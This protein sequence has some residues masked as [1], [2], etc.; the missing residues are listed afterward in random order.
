MKL[1]QMGVDP[2]SIFFVTLVY[3]WDSWEKHINNCET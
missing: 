3:A 2:P 1:K